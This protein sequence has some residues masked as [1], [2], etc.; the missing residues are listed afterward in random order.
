VT[1]AGVH[2]RGLDFLQR[3][4]WEWSARDRLTATVLASTL[5]RLPAP[6]RRRLGP[7]LLPV[8]PGLRAVH[9]GDPSGATAAATRRLLDEQAVPVSGQTDVLTLGL[10]DVGP[11]SVNSVLDPVLVAHLALGRYV[12]LHRNRPLVRKGGV[13]IVAHPTPLA[14][15]PV[16]HPATIDFFEQVLP[17]TTDPARLSADHEKAFVEDEWYR[18]L[19]RTSYAFHGSHP[20]HAW[21]EAAPALAHLGRVIVVGGDAAAVRRLGFKA[22]STMRDALE[23]AEDVVGRQ[24]SLTHLHVPPLLV[25]DVS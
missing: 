24:P 1:A 17:E 3:R 20:F 23:M 9:A 2:P 14:F 16:H 8:P 7:A 13:V 4:E 6:V 15:H 10:P 19:Y 21:Y 22:A 11:Y 18:H 5:G 12:A 25:A